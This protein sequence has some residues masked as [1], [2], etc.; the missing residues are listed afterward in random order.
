MCFFVVS[1]LELKAGGENSFPPCLLRCG[2]RA[3]VAERKIS[4][5]TQIAANGSLRDG[6]LSIME[7]RFRNEEI[8]VSVVH[9]GCAE[10]ANLCLSLRHVTSP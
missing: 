2:I 6:R 9:G 1:A 4:T 7:I 5:V 10:V 8:E 3:I